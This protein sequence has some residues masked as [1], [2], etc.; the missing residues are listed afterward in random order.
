M[1]ET[2]S[3]IE[4]A[5]ENNSEK[6]PLISCIVP[7]RDRQNFLSQLIK[8]FVNQDYKNKEMLI[9]DDSDEAYTGETPETVNYIHGE[10]MDYGAV[11]NMLASR[12]NGDI[13]SNWDDDDY[14]SPKYLSFMYNNMK[15]YNADVI[16]LHG[17]YIYSEADNS[18]WHWN[19][20]QADKIYFRVGW[21]EP[22]MITNTN[23]E[24]CYWHQ[25]NTDGFGWSM[26]YKKSMMELAQ[27]KSCF[28]ADGEFVKAIKAAGKLFHT[29]EDTQQIAIHYLHGKNCSC[30][31]PQ[32]RLPNHLISQ[33]F[34]DFIAHNKIDK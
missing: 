21:G 25:D 16:K 27:Y 29:I 13:I 9:Y 14:Y 18:L 12:A 17:W 26:L 4:N 19:T 15:K 34:P 31:Y 5:T 2:E 30:C 7:T 32:H 33:L 1:L 11:L 8:N 24:F 6:L 22:E 28:G 10:K 3:T 23:T 20:F